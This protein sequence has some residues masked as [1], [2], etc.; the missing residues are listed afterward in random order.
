[1]KNFAKRLLPFLILLLS[2]QIVFACVTLTDVT[3]IKEDTILCEDTYY[4]NDTTNDG[5]VI[6]NA[7]NV[8]L[9]CNNSILIGDGSGYGIYIS[10]EENNTIKNCNV[11]N[12]ENGIRIVGSTTKKNIIDNNNLSGNNYG[13]RKWKDSLVY[14]VS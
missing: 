5:A 3:F 9:D 7:S 8:I 4:I 6:I 1:M 12:Y 13:R 14:K 11:Q 10:G 2:F